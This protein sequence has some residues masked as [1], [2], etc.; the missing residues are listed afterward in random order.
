MIANAGRCSAVVLALFLMLAARP[1]QGQAGKELRCRGRGGAFV[2]DRVDKGT[3]AMRFTAGIKSAGAD[4]SGLAPGTCSFVDRVL[5]DAEPL[6]VH[7][8]ANAADL[9]SLTKEL[10]DPYSYWCFTVAGGTNAFFKVT[11]QRSCTCGDASAADASTTA[12]KSENGAK[13]DPKSAASRSGAA[14]SSSGAGKTEPADAKALDRFVEAQPNPS[15]GTSSASGASAPSKNENS[16]GGV[17]GGIGSLVGG[18]GKV[19]GGAANVASGAGKIVGGAANAAG[20]V[21]NA[22]S[23]AAN[24]ATAAAN[25]RTAAANAALT[26]AAGAA[27][28]VANAVSGVASN[29]GGAASTASGTANAAGGAAN[30]ASEAANT[31]AGSAPAADAA[32]AKGGSKSIADAAKNVL[33][34]DKRPPVITA[35]SAIHGKLEKLDNLS[36]AFKTFANI[37]PVVEVST[38]MPE[39]GADG[40]WVF[41]ASRTADKIEQTFL[42]TGPSVSLTSGIMKL[43]AGGNKSL[44]DYKVELKKAL[45][46]GSV[47]YYIIS[48]KNPIGSDGE[49]RQMKGIIRTPG[50]NKYQVRYRGVFSDSTNGAP[51][52]D[53][54]A[55]V[56]TSY[57]F[58]TGDPAIFST[59]PSQVVRGVAANE[60]HPD[61]GSRVYQ[62]ASADLLLT[63]T[64]MEN[65]GGD[66]NKYKTAVHEAFLS[67]V[68]RLLVSPTKVGGALQLV[69]NAVNGARA[70]TD[71]V[72]ATTSV[73]LTAAEMK[74]MANK[75]S[76]K[77]IDRGITYD[78]FTEHAGAVGAYRVY[79]DVVSR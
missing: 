24:V 19:V 39:R 59:L 47:Y 12:P 72:I 26:G 48:V 15:A 78:F 74:A 51:A 53:L 38:H 37:E 71:S 70:D 11:E 23:G 27:S 43:I 41:P 65:K 40:R 2:I 30:T 18:A 6:R 7:F 17:I 9:K 52:R 10:D 75:G 46:P 57:V 25:A 22:A 79:F 62:G 28:G 60:A 56:S 45:D 68:G 76:P 66:P 36:F 13:T 16:G 73:L 42:G 58:P 21:A 34:E 77:S 8:S 61:S 50:S 29:V 33:D 44:G 55:V 31:T 32:S 5:D 14:A 64:L 3:V 49:V 67:E 63:V 4:G 35:V 69:S 20:G 1:A 54:Y